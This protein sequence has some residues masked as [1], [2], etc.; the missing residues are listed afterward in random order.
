[1]LLRKSPAAQ[2]K[3]FLVGDVEFLKDDKIL[4]KYAPPEVL[5]TAN[6]TTL[7][8]MNKKNGQTGQTI[9]HES[10]DDNTSPFKALSQRIIHIV[11]NGRNDNNYIS[12]Y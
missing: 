11:T 3:K 12:D 2:T 4:S 9:N 6:T 8:M 10:L 1:M 5:L 7:K